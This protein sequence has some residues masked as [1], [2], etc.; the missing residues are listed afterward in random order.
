MYRAGDL[1][2]DIYVVTDGLVEMRVGLSILKKSAEFCPGSPT[3]NIP[4][5]LVAVLG[6]SSVVNDIPELLQRSGMDTITSTWLAHFEECT[7]VSKE[8]ATLLAVGKAQLLSEVRSQERLERI[9]WFVKSCTSFR[10][11]RVSAIEKARRGMIYGDEINE[12]KP[13]P[14][15]QAKDICEVTMRIRNKKVLQFDILLMFSNPNQTSLV[16]LV[17]PQTAASAYLYAQIREAR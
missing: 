2:P 16:F 8:P 9:R 3:H 10:W 12:R 14:L 13:S 17:C 15:Q 4:S 5:V 7:A 6:Q 1:T 11:Q